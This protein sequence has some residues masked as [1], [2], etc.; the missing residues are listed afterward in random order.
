MKKLL[1][2][3]LLSGCATTFTPQMAANGTN[4]ELCYLAMVKPE[5][6]QVAMSELIS[7]RADCGKHEAEIRM[8]HEQVMINRAS[9]AA[10]V[11]TLILNPQI[12]NQQPYTLSPAPRRST[13]C[14]TVSKPQGL[15]TICW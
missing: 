1:P 2:L 5:H 9:H 4:A 11:N 7:R 13:S 10:A 3:L 6:R 15:E 12:Y 8:I 14:Q